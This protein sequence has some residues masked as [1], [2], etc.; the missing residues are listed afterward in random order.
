MSVLIDLVLPQ[1]FRWVS[2][3]IEVITRRSIHDGLSD[4][5]SG[6]S[7]GEPF[8]FSSVLYPGTEPPTSR[9]P[10]LCSV[11]ANGGLCLISV[12]LATFQT[13]TISP[14]DC[15]S[16]AL[17]MR[18]IDISMILHFAPF[19]RSA[20]STLRPRRRIQIA[21]RFHPRQTRVEP[22]RVP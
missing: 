16:D 6:S 5:N 7:V 12:L 13:Q 14:S 17:R 1:L 11:L 21:R 20:I 3:P 9:S 19:P 22:R 10:S 4:I 15:A 18:R 2:T 8:A